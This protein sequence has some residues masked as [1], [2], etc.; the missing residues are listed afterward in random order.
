MNPNM[1]DLPSASKKKAARRIGFPAPLLGEESYR[2]EL[3]Y[4]GIGA[5]CLEKQPGLAL[6]VHPW[7]EGDA[8]I[9][10][11]LRVQKEAEKPELASLGLE[12]VHSIYFLEPEVSGVALLATNK[13]EQERLR[14]QFGSNEMAFAY[15]FLTRGTASLSDEMSCELPLA[16]HFHEKRAVVSARTGKK[17]QTHFKRLEQWADYELWEATTS[18]PR[19]HQIRIHAYECGLK[20][21]GEQLYGEP[22]PGVFMSSLKRKFRPKG[23]EAPLYKY[24]ALHLASISWLGIEGERLEVKSE[25]PRKF[26]VLLK[27]LKEHFG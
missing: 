26:S 8:T 4:H 6:E 7:Y 23:K 5:I 14:N 2:L 12:S 21:V 24:L 11:A 20:I 10:S 18:Y 3:L 15:R 22:V 1:S 25:L 9:V 13:L 27:K 17:S 16:P 19:P